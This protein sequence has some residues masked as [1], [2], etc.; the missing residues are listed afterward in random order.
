MAKTFAEYA[1]ERRAQMGP[2]GV[3]AERA[4]EAFYESLTDEEILALA[5]DDDDARD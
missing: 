5:T 4:F 1:R 2:E 3:V